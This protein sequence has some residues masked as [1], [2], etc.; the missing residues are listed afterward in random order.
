MKNEDA[1][2]VNQF[3]AGDEGAFTTLVKKYQK[4]V[5]ALAWRKV[6]DF[7]T[8]FEQLFGD[9]LDEILD[10]KKEDEEKPLPRNLDELIQQKEEG[11]MDAGLLTI[12]LEPAGFAGLPLPEGF[13]L[14]IPKDGEEDEI[15]FE[16]E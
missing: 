3:L 2:L 6:D 5:H 14:N 15:P 9:I 11:Q 13:P 1:R 8:A 10:K 4:S 7:H 12:T 16:K